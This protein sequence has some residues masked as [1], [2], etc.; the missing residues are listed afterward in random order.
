M[1]GKG[2][3]NLKPTAFRRHSKELDNDTCYCLAGGR[4]YYS[5]LCL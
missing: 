1:T 5:S 2:S 4:G 3:T